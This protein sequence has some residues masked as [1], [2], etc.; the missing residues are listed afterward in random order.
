M[1]EELRRLSSKGKVK[2]RGRGRGGSTLFRQ[3]QLQE[4]HGKQREANKPF[5]TE[6]FL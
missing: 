2:F 6:G 3:R 4:H 5:L 1:H